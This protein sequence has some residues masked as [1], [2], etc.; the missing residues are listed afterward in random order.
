M[1]SSTPNSPPAAACL[2]P[3]SA[4]GIAVVQVVGIDAPAVVNPILTA[5]RPVDVMQFRPDELRLCRIADDGQVLDDAIVASRQ[6]TDSTWVIDISVHGG[7]RI[8]HRLLKALAA[9]GAKLIDPAQLVQLGQTASNLLDAETVALLPQAKTRQVALWLMR[10]PTQLVAE[11]TRIEAML[12]TGQAQAGHT[13]LEQLAERFAQARY[14]LESIRVVLV[15]APNSGKSTLAN[16]LAG[17]EHSIVSPTA[18]TTRDWVEL[19]AAIDGVPITLVD[20]AGLRDTED[21]LEQEAMRRTEQQFA[22]ADIVL[23][24][25]DR[26]APPVLPCVNP[27]STDRFTRRCLQVTNKSDLSPH[28]QWPIDDE[29]GGATV[30]AMTG[31]GLADLRHR[32]L[33]LAGMADWTCRPAC[34]FTLRQYRACQAALVAADT[35]APSLGLAHNLL[36]GNAEPDAQIGQDS[37]GM[38]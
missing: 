22:T 32:I 11:A 13:A 28:P 5:K 37:L 10:S 24:V 35:G 7:T 20:T 17:A 21:A 14:L 31:A 27:P 15:G 19:P 4:G 26:T 29:R 38:V 36:W 3:P 30:S 25:V 1:P 12:A 8:V 16:A 34:P 9:N 6:V 18:G 2:T 23:C 33:V